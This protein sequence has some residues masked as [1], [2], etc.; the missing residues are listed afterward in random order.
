MAF[1]VYVRTGSDTVSRTPADLAAASG[2]PDRIEAETEVSLREEGPFFPVAHAIRESGA[3]RDELA[4]AIPIPS[5]AGY[6]RLRLVLAAL[7]APPALALLELDRELAFAGKVGPGRVAA[8][9][10]TVA[11]IVFE[12]TR[13]TP[14][15]P[16]V[17]ATCTAALALRWLIVATH[18]CGRGVHP[19]VW[20]S[21]TCAVLATGIF[22]VRVPPR[23][24]VVLELMGKL[25][26]TRSQLF[27]AT[28]RREPPG[29]L[30]AVAVACA[31]GLPALLH[32]VR[33][34]GASFLVQCL[35][36]IG[37]AALAPAAARRFADPAA[38]AA[39]RFDEPR[40]SVAP[41]RILFAVAIGL[42]IAAATVTAGRLF[43]DASA[44]LAQCVNRLDAEARLA[45]ATEAAELARAVARVRA[46]VPLFLMTAAVFPFAEER[47]YRGLLQDTLVRKY[48][49]AYGVFAASLAFGVAHLGVYEVA[50][51]QTV[52]LGIGFGFAYLEGGLL[53]AFFVHATW[54]L[55]QIG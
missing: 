14:R 17:A 27:A 18:A 40:A 51:Y 38:A 3:L 24:R 26:V 41:A 50:L 33:A 22:L 4:G 48:G 34:I 23:A 9:L 53:A 6:R 49:D 28:T 29:A 8:D 31:A 2:G 15:M 10:L 45:R 5:L 32:L 39:R 13:P 30:V 35:A 21:A 44:D 52:L 47:I 20:A 42:T 12:L 19:L 11:W 7:A 36:F 54:N 16:R 37:F 46:S 55:L 1:V 43:F 25:G